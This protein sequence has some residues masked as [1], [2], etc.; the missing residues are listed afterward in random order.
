MI[1]EA[2]LS[3]KN[4]ADIPEISSHADW[5]EEIKEKYA[6]LKEENLDKILQ[7]E[8]GLVFLQVLKDAGVYKRTV[9]GQEAFDRFVS[10]L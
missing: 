1:K 9:E 4:C 5:V 6:E 8:V 7:D 3:G 2:I 10:A